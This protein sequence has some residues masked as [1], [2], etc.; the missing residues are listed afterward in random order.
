MLFRSGQVCDLDV[1]AAKKELYRRYLMA[2]LTGNGDMHL[3]NISFLGGTRG[4]TLSPVYDPAPMRAWPQHD[5]RSAIPVGFRKAETWAHAMHRLGLAYGYTP[6]GW[7]QMVER[8]LA[9]TASYLEELMALPIDKARQDRL[10]A[11]VPAI[12]KEMLD[13]LSAGIKK[14][15]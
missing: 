10:A 14:S 8:A 7:R 11:I 6:T 1:A 9:D 4:T 3:E 5:V 15:N 13:L 12:R 2:M